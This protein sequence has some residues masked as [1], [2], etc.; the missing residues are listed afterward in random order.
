MQLVLVANFNGRPLSRK[1]LWTFER[2]TTTT[3]DDAQ[4]HCQTS[5]DHDMALLKWLVST[6]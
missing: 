1:T 3:I 4:R 5:I 2:A 6:S